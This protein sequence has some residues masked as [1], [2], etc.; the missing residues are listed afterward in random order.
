MKRINKIAI[1]LNGPREIDMY[2]KIIELIPRKKIEILISDITSSEV[3]R[4]TIN[5]SLKKILRKKR[6]KFKNFS[7][8]YKKYFYK[9]ILSSGEL[10]STK[11]TINSILKYLYSQSIGRL[12][13]I[14]KL[15][16]ILEKI[17]G[18]PF[19][20]AHRDNLGS[21]WYPEKDLAEV[22]VKLPKDLDLKLKVYPP[23]AFDKAFDIF[24]TISNFEKSIIKKRLENKKCQVIGYPRYNNLVNSRI[25]KQRVKKEFRIKDHKKIVFWTPTFI[26]FPKEQDQNILLWIEKISLLTTFY[27]IIIRPHPRTLA[28]NPNLKSRLKELNFFVDTNLSRDLGNIINASD[29]IMCDYGGTIFGSLYLRKP[30]LLLNTSEKFKFV[31]NLINSDSLD[32]KLRE[33]LI[34][35]NQNIS[36]E[37]I[38]AKMKYAISQRYQNKINIVRNKYFD[39]E[40]NI[41]NKNTKNFLLDLLKN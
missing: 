1:L 17:F 18:R 36:E 2:G 27:N 9:V 28:S 39:K 15:H 40:S 6:I 21:F 19:T 13:R 11:I 32:I 22:S 7:A 5:K 31:N 10:T 34:N 30:I 4:N 8:I 38:K 35:F 3:G 41:I 29:L 33:Q 26:H 16:I 25:I 24:F 37:E 23:K 20:G 12:I 14:L